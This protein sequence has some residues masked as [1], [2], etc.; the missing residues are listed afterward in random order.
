M[1]ILKL[2][3]S[4]TFLILLISC[5]LFLSC[6]TKEDRINQIK[7]LFPTAQITDASNDNSG[8]RFIVIDTVSKRYLF[9]EA[10]AD[11]DLYV[12]EFFINK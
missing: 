11:S 8:W 9:I 1:N 2:I 12:K 3:T 7:V 4:K 6:N 10:Y 5:F